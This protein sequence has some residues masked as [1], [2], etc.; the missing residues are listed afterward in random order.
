[1]KRAGTRSSR[2]GYRPIAAALKRQIIKGR[3]AP[4]QQLPGHQDLRS[5]FGTTKVTVQR[6]LDL[7]QAEGFLTA[8]RFRGTFVSPHPPHLSRYA[9]VFPWDEN[10]RRSQFYEGL[11]REAAKLAGPER[12]RVKVQKVPSVHHRF[13]SGSIA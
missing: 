1:M 12:D 4:G 2:P 7:L 9:L 3:L 5:R 13:H 11:R 10:D 8:E 6:A